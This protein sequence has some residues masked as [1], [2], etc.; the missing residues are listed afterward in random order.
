[1]VA[2]PGPLSG[3]GGSHSAGER[4]SSLSASK[5]AAWVGTA[6][7]APTLCFWACSHNLCA[8]FRCIR[9][10]RHFRCDARSA[11]GPARDRRSLRHV[12]APNL[13]AYSGPSNVG[14]CPAWPVQPVASSNQSHAAAVSAGYRRRRVLGPRTRWHQNGPVHI[15]PAR[16]LAYV[17]LP[18][19]LGVLPVDDMG[20]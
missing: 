9:S 12:T 7:C 13:L 15:L 1:M 18:G 20:V 4:L 19:A 14:I 5:T 3:L 8:R 6:A 16:G 2:T 17:V 11:Q 10:E